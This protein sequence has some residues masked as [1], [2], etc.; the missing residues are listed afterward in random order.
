MA[1]RTRLLEESL[2][3]AGSP[4]RCRS[5]HKQRMWAGGPRRML[6]RGDYEEKMEMPVGVSDSTVILRKSTEADGEY[7]EHLLS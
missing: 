5:V 2:K 4:A 6:S 3:G 1:L 7:F